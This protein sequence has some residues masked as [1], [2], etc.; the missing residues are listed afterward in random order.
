MKIL[1]VVAHPD[2]MELSMGGTI[3]KIHQTADTLCEVVPDIVPNIRVLILGEGVTSRGMDDETERKQL[4]ELENNVQKSFDMLECTHSGDWGMFP[5][6]KFESI[7]LLD[8]TKIIEKI[9]KTYQ[10]EVVY[11]HHHG[12]LNIDHRITHNAVM[13]A[14]RPVGVGACVK[15]I[16]TFEVLSSTEWNTP[17]QSNAFIPNYY[18]VLDKMQ[19]EK[20]CLA[21]ECY[22]DEVRQFPHPRSRQG[23]IYL[24]RKRGMEIGVEFAEAFG[25]V[26]WVE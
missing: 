20:K 2:D 7:P 23:I 10:P 14:C 19:I 1:I 5:D 11:T 17:I 15:K 4:I 13:T 26:R 24:A 8:I 18:M 22:K 12:D 25:V 21:L 16:L 9:I 3:T 6:N